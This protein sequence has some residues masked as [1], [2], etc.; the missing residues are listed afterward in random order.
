[1]VTSHLV[2]EGIRM[3]LTKFYLPKFCVKTVVKFGHI[4]FSESRMLQCGLSFVNLQSSTNP[5][6]SIYPW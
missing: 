4:S 1:M 2:S 5:E 6:Y 3:N